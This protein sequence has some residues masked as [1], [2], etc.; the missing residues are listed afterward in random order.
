MRGKIDGKDNLGSILISAPYFD[1][2]REITQCLEVCLLIC[3]LRLN[4]ENINSIMMIG[5][6]RLVCDENQEEGSC[7]KLS[8]I[9]GILDL[10]T[11]LTEPTTSLS[12]C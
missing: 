1:I 4:N 7:G 9:L 3:K 11:L 6:E 8:L 10:V 5:Q 2:T 12:T